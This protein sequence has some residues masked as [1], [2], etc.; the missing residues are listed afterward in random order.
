[1]L[2]DSRGNTPGSSSPGAALQQ[3]ALAIVADLRG[4]MEQVAARVF[5]DRMRNRR[6]GGADS[7]DF[8]ASSAGTAVCGLAYIPY[9][10]YVEG[11]ALAAYP[12]GNVTW[13]IQVARP[14]YPLTAAV[15]VIGGGASLVG[16]TSGTVP[17]GTAFT[18]P[19]EAGSWVMAF[20]TAMTTSTLSC[21]A[22][23]IRCL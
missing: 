20:C 14:G 5:D 15:S 2:P 19:I 21:A 4:Q 1:M 13:D 6:P 18:R 16:S 11:V 23:V 12:A 22:L 3:E 17:A 8:N 9:P 10:A 7:W